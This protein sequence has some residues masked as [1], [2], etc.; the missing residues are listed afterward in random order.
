MR[1]VIG[2]AKWTKGRDHIFPFRTRYA[3]VWE[4]R[5]IFSSGG[6]GAVVVGNGLCL[7][8][9]TGEVY[10]DSRFATALGGSQ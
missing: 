4:G 5:R 6:P 3:W 8:L 2:K 10:K 1:E 7:D 9:R